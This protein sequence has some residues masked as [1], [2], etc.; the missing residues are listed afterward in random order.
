[1]KPQ[2][3][4]KMGLKLPPTLLALHKN[5]MKIYFFDTINDISV[6]E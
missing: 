2:V 3:L 6:L 4:R 5:M 1:M